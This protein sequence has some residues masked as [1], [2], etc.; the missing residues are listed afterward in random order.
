MRSG[1]RD[2]RRDQAYASRRREWVALVTKRSA[3]DDGGLG[4]VTA[5]RCAEV[6][7][8]ATTPTAQ[9]AS[10]DLSGVTTG[11]SLPQVR[12]LLIAERVDGFFVERFTDSGELVSETQHE[13]MDEAMQQVDSEYDAI[14]EWRLC[15]DGADPLQYI[16]AQSPRSVDPRPNTPGG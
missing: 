1:N 6:L 13:T 10:G 3:D 15:P 12:V 16:R 7:S 5:T 4:H 14:S 9:A 2:G 8:V 11:R